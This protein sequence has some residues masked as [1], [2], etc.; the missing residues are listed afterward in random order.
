MTELPTLAVRQ[1]HFGDAV[2]EEQAPRS[3]AVL[4]QSPW[5]TRFVVELARPLDAMLQARVDRRSM[6]EEA[7]SALHPIL[8]SSRVLLT[9][10]AIMSCAAVATCTHAAIMLGGA[11]L[12]GPSDET[13]DERRQQAIATFAKHRA[14]ARLQRYQLSLQQAQQR[15]RN[16]A[17]ASQLAHFLSRRSEKRSKADAER[18]F[19]AEQRSRDEAIRREAAETLAAQAAVKAADE[20]ERRAAAEAKA[21]AAEA[22]AEH[23]EALAMGESDKREAAEAVA[24]QE[25]WA[26]AE[27]AVKAAEA[28]VQAAE[29][30]GRRAAAEAKAKAAVE[31]AEVAEA[32]AMR[33]AESRLRFAAEA[34]AARAAL[35][36]RRVEC[37]VCLD[38]EVRESEALCCSGTRAEG[39]DEEGGATEERVASPHYVCHVCTRQMA[40]LAAAEP[41]TTC[42]RLFC[43]LKSVG[44]CEANAY[45][46]AALAIALDEGGFEAYLKSRADLI[47]AAADA[48]VQREIAAELERLRGLGERRRS[49][50]AATRAI[51]EDVLTLKCPRQGCRRAFVDF[52]GCMALSCAGCGAGFCAWC[53]R[54]CGKDAHSHVW[55]CDAKP[56]HVKNSLFPDAAA[57]VLGQ[58]HPTFDAHWLVRKLAGVR[59][60]LRPLAR[61]VRLE[62]Y[63]ELQAQLE[64]LGL[65]REDVNSLLI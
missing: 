16:L 6:L 48:R 34:D 62:V 2:C 61:E 52:T 41:R 10:A 22:A 25:R 55:L 60:I 3:N 23:A 38:D 63:D 57:T 43:P 47:E 13:Q 30:M 37:V 8:Q 33:E 36:P 65:A 18:R 26:A 1:P 46:D 14:R 21:K 56:H 54:D 35:L 12:Y 5:S 50:E 45:T 20:M 42:R 9:T 64:P 51:V 39:G 49:I 32:L 11:M 59:A 28:A 31:A 24:N 44:R 15:E 40:A 27:A 29:E 7:K 53:L 19:A 4:L 17:S 58:G